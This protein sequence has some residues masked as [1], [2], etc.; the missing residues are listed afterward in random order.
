MKNIESTTIAAVAAGALTLHLGS[1]PVRAQGIPVEHLSNSAVESIEEDSKPGATDRYS[2]IAELKNSLTEG[3]D[4]QIT[5]QDRHSWLTV[6]APHGGHIEYGTS[7]L[8]R[9]IAGDQYNLFDFEALQHDNAK[10]LHVTST[11]FRDPVLDKLL[12]EATAAISLHGMRDPAEESE[13]VWLGGLNERLQKL[14][15][16]QLTTAGFS[17]KPD[18]PK[19]AGKSK[20]NF[21]NLTTNGGVQMELSY[22]LRQRM[23]KHDDDGRALR[24]AFVNAVRTAAGLYQGKG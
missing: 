21:V 12:N 11:R 16:D 13:V 10:Q 6:V 2:S 17:V 9:E 20:E 3:T 15:L 4:Y 5:S 19:L 1:Q 14:V 8:A 23:M 22:S 7:Q 18:P 24:K